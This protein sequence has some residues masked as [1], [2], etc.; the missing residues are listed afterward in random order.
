MR[1]VSTLGECSSELLPRWLGGSTGLEGN[2]ER[3]VRPEFLDGLPQNSPGARASRRDLRIINRCLG[4]T[5]WFR[6]VLRAQVRPGERVLEI[7]AGEGELGRA[8]NPVVP[9][10]AGLDLCSRPSD[11]PR[12]AAWFE[13]NVLAFTGWAEFPV[14]IGNLFF[15]HFDHAG[16]AQL[17]AKLNEHARVIIANEPLRVRRA[18][19]L[20]AWLC[21]L[22]RAHP[23]TRYDGRVSVAAGFRRDELSHLLHLDP[24][25][26][27]W[28]AQE[29][30]LGSCRFVA[31]RRA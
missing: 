27:T 30:W 3:V 28:R 1:H 11:W 7:G 20:F 15:H 10:M 14:V 13:T 29:N 5:G 26:W 12:T 4:S 31:V 9:G 2:G 16:L 22:I 19:R 25:A 17:G 8:L 24:A 23:V 21:L 6:Q 18:E